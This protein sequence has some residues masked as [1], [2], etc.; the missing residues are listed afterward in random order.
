MN[1][2]DPRLHGAYVLEMG[3]RLQTHND[4][5]QVMSSTLGNTD[6]VGGWSG[7]YC[8]WESTQQSLCDKGTLEQNVEHVGDRAKWGSG[9]MHVSVPS[10][11]SNKAGA[12]QGEWAW[13]V[14]ETARKSAQ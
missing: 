10:K 13:S 4:P 9:R 2:P 11:W 14:P 8:V 6:E 1:N 12:L 3:V 5:R 7:K